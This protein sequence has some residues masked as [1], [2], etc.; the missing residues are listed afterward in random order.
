MC[1][2]IVRVPERAAAG[3]VAAPV[4]LLAVRDEDPARPWDPV[5]PWWPRVYPGVIGVRD[6]RAGGA[7][8]AADPDAR[9][10]SVILNRADLSDR[11][12]D[13]VTSRGA[14][15]LDSVVGHAVTG[16]PPT[17]GFNLVEV[18]TDEVRVLSWDGLET[19][20]RVLEPGT[21]M[22]A[23]DDVDD[24]TTARIARWLSAFRAATP[25][26]ETDG[27]W[28]APWLDVLD[29]SATLSPADDKAIIR[30]NRPH[31]YPTQ[32]LLACAATISR[33][34]VEVRDGG[35]G[36]PGVWD[37]SALG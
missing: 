35:F 21:H 9:R 15:V 17:R 30:D 23:H 3:G 34:G 11:T 5:G 37:R 13:E 22:I 19:R 31:G 36:R 28:F 8:L 6:V 16:V 14:V 27:D 29:E 33:T 20:E 12:D 4:H 2:V 1:T 25:R 24:D 10:L 32:S 7:W 18:S 26:T